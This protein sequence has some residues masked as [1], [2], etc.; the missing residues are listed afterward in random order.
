MK[1]SRVF[2]VAV[3]AVLALPIAAAS[4]VADD[5]PPGTT[6]RP[7]HIARGES[8]GLLHLRGE[9]IVDGDHRVRV[10][11]GRHLWLLGRS[12][13]AYVLMALDRDYEQWQLLRVHRDGRTRVLADGDRFPAD[14]Q[15]SHDGSHVVLSRFGDKH[16]RIR[17]LDARSG[18]LLRVRTFSG[19]PTVV[20]YTDR[21]VILSFWSSRRT[22][23]LSW[24]PR[25]NRTV[26]IA[27]QPAYI[28]DVSADRLGLFI[29]EAPEACQRVVR[30]SDP[31]QTLWHSCRNRALEFSPD[32]RRM[33]TTHI[34]SDGPGPRLIQVRRAHGRVLATYRS[35]WF[36][37]LVWENRRSVLLETGGKEFTAAVRCTPPGDCE[38][39]S[40][41]F[42]NKGREPY[43]PPAMSWSFPR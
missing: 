43:L 14:P 38:R 19:F 27:D 28:A 6:L 35:Q 39:A 33:I 13:R 2:A 32:G 34:L 42:R 25:T 5:N 18:E 31:S 10:E 4:A 16:T 3:A 7:A 40:K 37:F 8:T 26:R 15:L 29:S 36:G 20:E 41:L 21:R 11:E 24:N 17:V 1:Q 22:G 12:G 9:V 23:T 30:L